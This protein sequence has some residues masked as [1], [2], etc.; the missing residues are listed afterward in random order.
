MQSKLFL[1]VCAVLSIAF[2][3]VS[4]PTQVKAASISDSDSLYA[5]GTVLYDSNYPPAGNYVP[6]ETKWGDPELGTPGGVVT[7]SFMP[8]GPSYR[9][10]CPDPGCT[11]EIK[12]LSTFMPSG[13]EAE[14]KRAFDAWS[15]VANIQFQLVTDSGDAFNNTGARG[16]IRFGGHIFDGPSNVLAHGYFPQDGAPSYAGDI[17]FDIEDTWKIGFGGDGFDIFQVTAHEI[18]HAIGLDH[19]RIAN[20]LMNPYYTE[21]I[22]GPQ[23]NDIAGAQYIYGKAAIVPTPGLLVPMLGAGIAAL[24]K[25][26]AVKA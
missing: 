18:G 10:E 20:S 17:H 13:F 24:R 23:P 22:S 4:I 15:A 3:A 1:N 2:G 16:N 14:I 11:D 12:A 21:S 25:R 19:T 9:D 26:K 7:Y 8:T 6:T 5:P